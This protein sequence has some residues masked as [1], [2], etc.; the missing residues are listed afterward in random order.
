MPKATGQMEAVA[1]YDEL[2]AKPGLQGVEVWEEM[3]SADDPLI[4]HDPV[5]S[6]MMAAAEERSTY[7]AYSG[8]RCQLQ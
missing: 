3:I 8:M 4:Q 5:R 7:A 6:Q 2:L 1:S